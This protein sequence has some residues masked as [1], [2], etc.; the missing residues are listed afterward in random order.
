MFDLLVKFL[1]F[2]QSVWFAVRICQK[3]LCVSLSTTRYVLILT[4]VTIIRTNLMADHS[5]LVLFMCKSG[6]WVKT[7]NSIAYRKKLV[8]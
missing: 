4:G 2:F 5:R 3:A 7:E 8:L 1:C 6:I